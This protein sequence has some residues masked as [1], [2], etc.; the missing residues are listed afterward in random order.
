MGDGT[1][2]DEVHPVRSGLARSNAF[3]KAM[4]FRLTDFISEY[5]FPQYSYG[6]DEFQ[7]KYFKPTHEMLKKQ[8]GLPDRSD[9]HE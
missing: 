9:S 5:N 7:L 8:E 1:K 2:I 3:D 6:N 4:L